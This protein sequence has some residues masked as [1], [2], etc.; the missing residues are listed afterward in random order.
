MIQGI[1]QITVIGKEATME[2]FRA[3]LIGIYPSLLAMTMELKA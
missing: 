3:S 2:S 1:I